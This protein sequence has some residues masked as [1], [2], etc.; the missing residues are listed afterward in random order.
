MVVKNQ[1]AKALIKGDVRVI[2][3][4]VAGMLVAT[5]LINILSLYLGVGEFLYIIS[6]L[7]GVVIT[8]Y[9]NKIFKN[10][11]MI[12]IFTILGSFIIS[13]SLFLIFIDLLGEHITNLAGLTIGLIIL[14]LSR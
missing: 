12:Y 1:L 11:D 13:S 2:I 4:F 5:S 6:L 3:G 10:K 14:Y 7:L 9:S 8:M